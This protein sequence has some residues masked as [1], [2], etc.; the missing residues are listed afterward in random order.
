MS[1]KLDRIRDIQHMLWRNSSPG[2][3]TYGA[4]IRCA[5]KPARGGG[6]CPDCAL[7]ELKELVGSDIANN[8]AGAITTIR[9]LEQDME[10]KAAGV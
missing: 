7:A 1:K 4:C 5:N 6:L 8:Y 10:N 3:H 2:V 9:L